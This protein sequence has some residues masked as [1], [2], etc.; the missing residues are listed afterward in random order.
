M[1]NKEKNYI[2]ELVPRFE[3]EFPDS[4][5]DVLT[6][7][8]YK[9]CDVYNFLIN[10][11]NKIKT[12]FNF[13]IKNKRNQF[14]IQI[15]TT[16]PYG[17]LFIENTNFEELQKQE[18]ILITQGHVCTRISEHK[19]MLFWCNQS[20]CVKNKKG[21]LCCCKTKIE[22]NIFKLCY[23]GKEYR[24][25]LQLLTLD[26]PIQSFSSQVGPF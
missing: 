3:L 17:A 10:L 1:A 5:S 16:K 26:L 8:P 11:Y 24:K 18:Q 20:E 25:T 15:D 6:T 22:N 4:K 7:T 2:T 19:H 23:Y 12:M 9:P 14:A 13:C 21:Q